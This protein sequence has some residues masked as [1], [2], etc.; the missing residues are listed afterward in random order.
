MSCFTETIVLISM[1]SVGKA[2]AALTELISTARAAANKGSESST[3]Q[4]RNMQV[5]RKSNP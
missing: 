5:A 2:L 3:L 1:E 4:N